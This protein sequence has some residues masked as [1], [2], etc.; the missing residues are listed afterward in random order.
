MSH[1]GALSELLNVQIERPGLLSLP[2]GNIHWES[3]IQD[4]DGKADKISP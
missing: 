2:T 4:G 1:T 3:A